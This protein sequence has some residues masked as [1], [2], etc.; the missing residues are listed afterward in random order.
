MSGRSRGPRLRAAALLAT[1][2]LLG[3]VGLLAPDLPSPLGGPP[4]AA[5]ASP[6]LTIVG[7]ARYVVQPEHDRVRVVVDLTVAN[8]RAET[9]IRRYWFDRGFLVVPPG[10]TAFS[11][12]ADGLSPSVRVVSRPRSYT[13]IELRFGSRVYSGRSMKLRL[14]FSLPDPGG[15][16]LRPLRVGDSLVAL[17][18]WAF[19]S[20]AT[21]GGTVSVVVP[22]GYAVEVVAGRFALRSTSTTGATVLRTGRLSKPLSFF[23]YVVGEGPGAYAE[24]SLT[25]DAGGVPVAVDVRAWAD[26]PAWAERVGALVE[27]ALPALAEVTGIPFRGPQ[28]LVITESVAG[29]LD[30]LA[31]RF[32]VA[33]AHLEVAYSAPDAVVVRELAHA[34]FNGELAAERWAVEGFAGLAAEWAAA[35]M[36]LEVTPAELTPELVAERIPL[37]DWLP[38]GPQRTAADA[39]A[40]VASVELARHLALRQGE[41]GLRAAWAALAERRSAYQPRRGGAPLDRL[42]GPPDWRGLLDVIEAAGGAPADNLWREWV[43]RPDQASLLAARATARAELERVA[44]AAGEWELPASIRA[45][46]AAWRFDEAGGLLSQA[47]AALD[48]RAE[49]E[50]RA[51]AAGLSLPAA[52]ERSFEGDRGPRAAIA[53]GDAELG[54]ASAIE[55]AAAARPLDPGPLEVTGLAGEAPE[56]DLAAARTAFALGDL[57]AAVEHAAAAQEVWA[58]APNV[59]RTRLTLA[60]LALAAVGLLALLVGRRRRPGPPPGKRRWPMAHR[61]AR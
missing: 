9:V 2:A 54:A 19:A 21:S 50:R 3:P 57:A 56:V 7:D 60:G 42:S 48:L 32:D 16:P 35:A 23:A 33:G 6:D 13:L 24:R 31:A 12:T 51:G 40:E 61:V 5:A 11:L 44:T 29:S 8:R 47:S 26:D 34:W 52:L 4:P 45:A 27:R 53:E 39:Y 59:G 38:P 18:V 46:M 41:E 22:A 37:N 17:P 55:A 1:A 20:D 10:S 15:S 43:V 49:L 36:D 25:V 30:G 28:S 14:A 58:A